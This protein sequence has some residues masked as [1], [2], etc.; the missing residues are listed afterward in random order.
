MTRLLSPAA[1]ILLALC[2]LF[3][4]AKAQANIVCSITSQSISFGTGST[5]T[6][7]LGY[8]CVS[9]NLLST[10][11]TLC[12][13]LGTPSYPGSVAQPKMIDSANNSLNFNLY[14]NAARTTVWSGSTMITKAITVPGFGS[15]SGTIPFYGAI[16][17]GQGAPPGSYT[18]S[19]YNTSLGMEY[20]GSCAEHVLLTF[21]GTNNTLTATATVPS[22][23]TLATNT[24]ALSPVASTSTNIAGSTTL[25]VTCTSGTAYY[26]GLA[27]SNGSTAGAGVLS[28]SVGNSDKPP[29]QLRS[30]SGTSGTIWD[31]TA[32]TTS[33]GNGVSGTGNGSAQNHTV[34]VTLPSANYRPDSY[35]DTVTVN[36]NY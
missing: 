7:T 34:Y 12:S 19:F 22:T 28:G 3:W 36:V 35:S 24:M 8:S 15:V 23:C 17:T 5:A 18:A 2:C 11:L 13:T 33:V 1:A 25:S 29:Y 4:P 26:I 9:Y 6:G 32:T 21:D 27:P 30:T 20:F 31:N 14:T 16:P 10:S